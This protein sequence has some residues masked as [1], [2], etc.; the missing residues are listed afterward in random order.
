[1]D[2]VIPSKNIEIAIDKKNEKPKNINALNFQQDDIKT[3]KVFFDKEKLLLK[4]WQTTDMYNNSV[5][6][7]IKIL[8]VNNEEA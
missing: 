7:E 4:G 6:T 8:E 2:D 5:F 1:M 3:I